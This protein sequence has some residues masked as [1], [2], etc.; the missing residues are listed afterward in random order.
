MTGLIRWRL[1]ARKGLPVDT[2]RASRYAHISMAQAILVVAMVF[3]A[4]AMARGLF[5]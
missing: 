5:P 2:G 3:A 4:T 1:L